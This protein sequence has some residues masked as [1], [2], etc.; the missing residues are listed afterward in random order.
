MAEMVAEGTAGDVQD[1][2]RNWLPVMSEKLFDHNK[3]K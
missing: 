3:K 2:F 1:Y